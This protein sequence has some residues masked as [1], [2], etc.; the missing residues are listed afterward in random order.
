[1][2]TI[3]EVYELL[4]AVNKQTLKLETDHASAFKR[5]EERSNQPEA[6]ATIDQVYKLLDAV[7]RLETDNANAFKRIEER[8][9]QLQESGL[10]IAS[11]LRD[12]R[13]R[14]PYPGAAR[15]SRNQKKGRCIDH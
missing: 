6:V 14:T 4:N 1:M 3:D 10:N 12:I 8:F 2:A 5:I 15:G 11:G 9:N 13:D 7:N